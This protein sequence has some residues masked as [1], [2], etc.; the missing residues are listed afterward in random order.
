M[1]N[2]IYEPGETVHILASILPASI[3]PRPEGVPAQAKLRVILTTRSITVAWSAGTIVNVP[4]IGRVDIELTP[5]ESAAATSAGGTI[6]SYSVARGSG[7]PC[8][9]AALKSWN[10]FPG[11]KI[12]NGAPTGQ[13]RYRQA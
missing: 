1:T 11:C 8:G 7:C 5:E 13:P 3:I 12:I 6:G 10:P 4:E 2:G 9:S